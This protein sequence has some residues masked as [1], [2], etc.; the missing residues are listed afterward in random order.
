MVVE[1]SLDTLLATMSTDDRRTLASSPAVRTPTT[2]AC[3]KQGRSKAA[4]SSLPVTSGR[5]S[6]SS[7]QIALVP[8]CRN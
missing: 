8:T 1:R 2:G 7:F 4:A 5:E 6:R 3:T